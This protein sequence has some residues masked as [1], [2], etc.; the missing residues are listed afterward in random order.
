MGDLVVLDVQG[1]IVLVDD[2]DV[3]HTGEGRGSSGVAGF[4]LGACQLPRIARQ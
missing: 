4:Y 2:D 3:G 1:N